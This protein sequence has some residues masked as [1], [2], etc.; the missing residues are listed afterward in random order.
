MHFY[1]TQRCPICPGDVEVIP[2]YYV[3]NGDITQVIKCDVC[4]WVQHKDNMALSSVND[5]VELSNPE[6]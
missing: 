4:G 1:D 2:R 6:T 5:T 3:F